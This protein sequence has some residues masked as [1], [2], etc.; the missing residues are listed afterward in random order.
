M[1]NSCAQAAQLATLPLELLMII[2]DLLGI[3]DLLSLEINKCLRSL[4]KECLRIRLRR[5][6]KQEVTPDGFSETAE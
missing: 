2:M 6:V 5:T 4:V 3:A 1:Q